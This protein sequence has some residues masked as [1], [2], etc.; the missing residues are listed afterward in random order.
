MNREHVGSS[1]RLRDYGVLTSRRLVS[2]IGTLVLVASA[3]AV[4][5]GFVGARHGIAFSHFDWSL[6]AVAG[7]AVG[8]VLLAGFTGAL[9]W[10]TSGDVR[11]T[12]RLAD[13][14]QEDQR[15]RNRPIVVVRLGRVMPVAL[16]PLSRKTVPALQL[17]MKN[18]GLGPA[19]NLRLQ[20][21]Y[22]SEAVPTEEVIAV[23]AVDEEV[24]DRA[25]SLAGVDEP[26][27]GF[28]LSDFRL[29]G[30]CTDRTRTLTEPIVVLK[31][32]GLPDQVRAAAEAAA[33]QAWLELMSGS[34]DEPR[35]QEIRYATQVLN[36]GP[37]DALDVRLQLVDDNGV[38]LGRPVIVGTMRAHTQVGVA[39]IAPYPQPRL[40][41]R[42]TWRD[43]RGPES[44]LIDG[45]YQPVGLELPES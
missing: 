2:W 35:G 26:E 12:I 37:A 21:T 13:A 34:H 19:L 9:A 8:T 16:D 39:V 15:A 23:V 45:A 29:S 4:L 32:E 28:V 36:N 10:T 44:R 6:A 24:P 42:I 41:C 1:G 3:V 30:E 31:D 27:G 7:T 17:W 11:A 14:T 25:I 40:S 38:D 43:G 5:L 20:A 33:L 22:G 18:V